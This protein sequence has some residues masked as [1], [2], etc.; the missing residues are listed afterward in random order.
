VRE[1]KNIFEGEN[2]YIPNRTEEDFYFLIIKAIHEI[3]YVN[4]YVQS[5]MCLK[6]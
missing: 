1:E 2:K 5:G 6:E 3:A 4:C